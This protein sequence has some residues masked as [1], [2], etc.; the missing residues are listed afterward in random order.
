MPVYNTTV[1]KYKRLEMQFYALICRMNMLQY[2]LFRGGMTISHDTLVD[3]ECDPGFVKT[4]NRPVQ[5][6]LGS[7]VPS[8][9]LCVQISSHVPRAEQ[10]S[11]RQNEQPRYIYTH[12]HK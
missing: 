11:Y 6:K 2:N 7:I 4:H 10:F 3:Y 1:K 9:P 5:C 8:A 12:S